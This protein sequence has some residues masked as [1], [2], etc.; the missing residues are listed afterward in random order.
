MREI[1][2]YTN[3]IRPDGTKEENPEVWMM[4]D[5]VD[6]QVAKLVYYYVQLNNKIKKSKEQNSKTTITAIE[7]QRIEEF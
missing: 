7:R 1:F 4:N 5:T 2:G 3:I 6:N